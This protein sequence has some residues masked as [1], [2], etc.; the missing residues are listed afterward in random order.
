VA[1]RVAR[2]IRARDGGDGR[3]DVVAV[4]GEE[5]VAEPAAVDH[6]DRHARA[7]LPAPVRLG[8][9][10]DRRHVVRDA[11]VEPADGWR[12]GRRED[13]Q[14]RP[15]ALEDDAFDGRRA[16]LPDAQRIRLAGADDVEVGDVLDPSG[17][18]VHEPLDRGKR[19]AG[20]LLIRAGRS[21][22]RL[23]ETA[24]REDLEAGLLDRLLRL[25]VVGAAAVERLGVGHVVGVEERRAP[26]RADGDVADDH[27]GQRVAR[28]EHRGHR[29][30]DSFRRSLRTLVQPLRGDDRDRLHVRAELLGDRERALGLGAE[31]GAHRG[32]VPRRQKAHHERHDVKAVLPQPVRDDAG[33]RAWAELDG[34]LDVLL[35]G[36]HVP[37]GG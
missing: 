35:L 31:R 9:A 3:L 32:G 4:C 12:E 21:G 1:V 33:V 5:R 6:R 19:A 10:E 27:L 25:R 7:A 29:H 14:R 37:R 18:R 13:R 20:Q 23:A 11:Q 34:D 17:P 30:G 36:R 15:R 24:L 16:A 28:L 2:G 8:R 26:L 22:D